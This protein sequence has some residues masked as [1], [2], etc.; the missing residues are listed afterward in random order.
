M[1]NMEPILQLIENYS[2]DVPFLLSIDG[3]SASGK[4][5]LAMQLADVWQYNIIH[6]DDFYLPFN[7][8][9]PKQ[10]ALP[11]G[12]IDFERLINEVLLPLKSGEN[13][14]Y[15]PYDCHNN[16]FYP[17]RFLDGEKCTILEGSYSCHP[18]LQEYLDLKV[19]MD[20]SPDLQ[21]ERLLKRNP[22]ALE[23]FFS[24]WIPRE[25][26]YF[27]VCEIRNSCNLILNNL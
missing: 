12:N 24:T 7:R 25:E 21:K 15:Q 17:E 18:C 1:N 3:R 8:R 26:Y 10:M 13:V 27:N 23:A 5:T 9:T 16:I 4:T 2:L 11:G 19:F 22:D 20:I 6:M 14:T